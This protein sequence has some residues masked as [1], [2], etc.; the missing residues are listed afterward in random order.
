MH[1]EHLCIGRNYRPNEEKMNLDWMNSSC[2]LVQNLKSIRFTSLKDVSYLPWKFLSKLKNLNRFEMTSFSLKSHFLKPNDVELLCETCPNLQCLTFDIKL[3]EW[4][5][6]LKIIS[7]LQ[8]L[9]SLHIYCYFQPGLLQGFDDDQIQP[10][11]NIRKLTLFNEAYA[12]PESLRKWMQSVPTLFP[13]VESLVIFF[14]RITDENFHEISPNSNPLDDGLESYDSWNHFV[15]TQVYLKE[16]YDFPKKMSCLKRFKLL[17]SERLANENLAV[18][19]LKRHLVSLNV[20][21][22]FINFCLA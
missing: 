16:F 22:D 17:T 20:K 6:V 11:M 3:F 8:H 5:V 13:K 14:R 21:F 2:S 19:S 15:F 18:Q 4:K 1:L 10:L 9:H 7:Q 12:S